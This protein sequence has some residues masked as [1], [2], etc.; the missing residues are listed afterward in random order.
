MCVYYK[1]PGPVVVQCFPRTLSHSPSIFFHLP[2][3]LHSPDSS[4][5]PNLHLILIWNLLTNQPGCIVRLWPPDGSKGSE[6]L[7]LKMA[8]RQRDPHSF[9]L[10]ENWIVHSQSYDHVIQNNRTLLSRRSPGLGIS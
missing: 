10:F 7:V 3:S 9:T 8:S 4:H 5:T 1:T 2:G 6:N